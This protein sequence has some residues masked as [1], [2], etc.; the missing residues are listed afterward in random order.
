MEVGKI[1]RAL[2]KIACYVTVS[3]LLSSVRRL[4]PTC[5]GVEL[6]TPGI[7]SGDDH[8]VLARRVAKRPNL[9]AIGRQG[10]TEL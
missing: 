2:D 1:L 6:G 3:Q 5:D 10:V 8:A 9:D 7:R 4:K